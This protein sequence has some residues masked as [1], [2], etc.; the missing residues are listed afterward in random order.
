MFSFE[1]RCWDELGGA[2]LGHLSGEVYGYDVVDADGLD[3]FE[4]ESR[5]M[6]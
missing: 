5:S 4:A 2:E 3:G 6:R 1:E